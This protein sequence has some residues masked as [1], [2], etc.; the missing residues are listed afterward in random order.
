MV[1]DYRNY[2]RLP[3]GWHVGSSLKL[4]FDAAFLDKWQAFNTIAVI[5]D[6]QW[7]RWVVSFIEHQGLQHIAC[8]VLIFL[9]LA[10][11]LERQ[12]GTVRILVIGASA[13]VG[14]NLLSAV[15][16]DPCTQVVGASGIIFGLAGFWIAD[17][18]VNFHHIESVLKHMILV[19]VFFVLFIITVVARS[20]VSN[21]SHLGGF[22]AGVQPALI[23]LPRF[24]RRRLEASLLY[25]GIFGSLAYFSI[26]FP[27][28][29]KVKLRGG[30]PD[31][32]T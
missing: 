7:H 9:V 17:L 31:C 4:T 15:L 30:I 20:N 5:R 27:I 29:Y 6:G 21:W 24:G 2:K 22:I 19:V 32:G 11:H 18:I 13:G 1:A 14:G 28:A 16:E 3:V 23:V 12:Y 25:T 8:N 10:S 26:L